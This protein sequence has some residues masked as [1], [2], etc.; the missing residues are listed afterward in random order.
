MA[1][2]RR[3]TV[4]AAPID[5]VWAILRDFNGH[6]RWHPAVER[7]EVEFGEPSD[8]VGCIRHFQ[9]RDGAMLREQLL[10][11]SD[12]DHSFRYFIVEAPVP[13]RN[14]VAEMRL[15]PVS[16]DGSTFCEWRAEFEPPPAERDPLTRFVRE[17]IIDAGFEALRRAVSGE[18]APQARSA[19]PPRPHG[20]RDAVA[21]V[22]ARW[23]GPEAMELRPIQVADPGAGE[24]RI[25]QTAIGLNFID[26]YCRRGSFTMV[27]PGGVLGMEA[28]GVVESVGPGVSAL[29]PGDRVAYACA[30]PGAYANLRNMRADMLVRLP[31]SLSDVKAA[32]LMLKGMTASFLLHDVYA[33]KPGDHILVHAAAGGVGQI[34]CR[35]AKAIGARVIGVTST[36]AKAEAARRAGCDEA[37]LAGRP[38]LAEEVRRLTGERGVDVVY[39]AVGADTFETSI[40]CL[41]PRGHLVSFGQASGDVGSRSIDALANRSVTLSRPNY[42][43]YT[44][45]AD[46]IGLQSR[47][48]FEALASGAVVADQPRL[49]PL[50]DVRR[51]HADLEGRATV[52]SLVLIP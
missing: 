49:Y 18:A 40:A 19:A 4:I 1:R 29:K 44:D 36:E 52:G 41:A 3:S 12:R 30:P 2:I 51:A 35:W 50:P 17:E 20:G 10:S 37:L 25:R 8:K 11:L 43:H 28:A 7:S 15:S 5:R 9:L 38:D 6:D 33:V 24:V 47:R 26:V 14:Y 42:G 23:G 34:L 13:L 27:P 22:L 21:V 32:A 39:D 46:K 31:S 45:T 48:L 16:S